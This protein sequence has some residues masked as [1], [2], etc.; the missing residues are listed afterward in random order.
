MGLFQRYVFISFFKYI[1]IVGLFVNLMS[2]ISSTMGESKDLSKYDYSI[3][4]FIMLQGYNMALHFNLIMPAIPT[5]AAV[6]VI[7]ILMRSNELLAYVSLGGTITKLAVPFITVGII[8]SSFMILWEYHVIPKVRV[9]REELRDKM[10]GKKYNRIAVYN[11]I[12]MMDANNKIINIKFIDMIG[13]TI[14]GITQYNINNEFTITKIEKI[15]EAVKVSNGWKISNFETLDV[16]SN[17]P[18]I[19]NEASK[20]VQ[21]HLWDDLM[22]VAV[23]DIRALS[24]TQLSTLSNI[25]A[26]HG[27]STNKY[28]MLYYSKYANAISVIVLLIL[29]FPIAINFSRN[30]SIVK[31]AAVTIVL[32]LLFWVVQAS[33]YSLGDTGLLSPFLSN[34]LP[35]ITFVIISSVIIYFRQYKR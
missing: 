27:M 24:P 10:Q 15:N 35:L 23:V 26:K 18:K 2:L 16:S 7:I 8:M 25:M 28:D 6:I 19:T 20:I 11:D 30:Y 29:V 12:W 32:G 9:D 5:I 34:F 1:F 21:N 33:C 4:D 17:P 14:N 22:K 31:N 13:K 3:I